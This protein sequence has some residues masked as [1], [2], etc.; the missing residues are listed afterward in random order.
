MADFLFWTLVATSL[1]FIFRCY[2]DVERIYQYP[3]LSALSTLVFVVPT[4]FFIKDEKTILPIE[5]YNR[6]VFNALLCFWAGV[7]GYSVGL[8]HFDYSNY[9]VKHPFKYEIHYAKLVRILTVYAVLGGLASALIPASTFGNES[10]GGNFAITLY[11]ARLLRPT[12][13]LVFALYLVKPT[14]RLLILFIIWFIFSAEFLVISGRRSEFFTMCMVFMFP[15]FMI[16]GRKVNKNL[17]LPGVI[18]GLFVVV[19]FPII[20]PYTKSGN[21]GQIANLSLAPVLQEYASGDRSNEIID[22]SLNMAAV[23]RTGDYGYLGATLVNGFTNQYASA[24]LFGKDFK[25][26]LKLDKVNLG[27]LRDEYAFSNDSKGFKFYLTQTGYANAFLE[28]GYFGG[29]LFFI[30]AFFCAKFYKRAMQAGNFKYKVFYCM[31]AVTILFSVYDNIPAILF[32]Y[33][34]PYLLVYYHVF[35]VNKQRKRVIFNRSANAV[36]ELPSPGNPDVSNN[37]IR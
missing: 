32:L 31:F 25:D 28:L 9:Q 12:A 15:L 29:L 1:F 7:I 5:D 20:R 37:L 30:F 16:G 8:K 35:S 34:P 17:I 33:L 14:P 2:N 19:L 21:Y 10:T 11:F 18:L 3:A 36:A 23:A 6:F 4:L 24:T 26:N 22:A 27:E 13:I